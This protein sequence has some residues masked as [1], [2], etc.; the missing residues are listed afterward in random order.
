MGTKGSY[1]G[2]KSTSAEANAISQWI[3]E[4]DGPG[5]A[6]TGPEETVDVETVGVPASV[7]RSVLR[8][9]GAPGSGDGG[10]AGIL[11]G[12]SVAQRAR[13]STAGRSRSLSSSSAAAGRAAGAAFAFR[14]GN[15]AALAQLGLNY[16][17]LRNLQDPIDVVSH[18]VDAVCGPL[19]DGT[20]EGDERR[21]VAAHVAGWVLQETSD[22]HPPDTEE[23]VRTSIASVLFE[24]ITTEIAARIRAGGQSPSATLQAEQKIRNAAQ[25][26]ADNAELSPGG[27]TVPE[28]E[29]AVEGGIS[30]L[31]EIF[32]EDD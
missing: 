7:L 9:A 12:T 24:A 17:T 8:I 29:R 23:I 2:S 20:V 3:E 25:V 4:G 10:G 14:V 6:V 16:A 18:I 1:T 5:G 31:R 15:A 27:A 13:G 22:D 19:S 28:L 11:G 32:L 21:S 30:K 26:L